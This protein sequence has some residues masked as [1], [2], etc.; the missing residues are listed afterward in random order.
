[1]NPF[2]MGNIVKDKIRDIEADAKKKHWSKETKSVNGNQIFASIFFQKYMKI[3]FFMFIS[4]IK[5]I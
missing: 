4:A 3:L 2:I 5:K 1:M